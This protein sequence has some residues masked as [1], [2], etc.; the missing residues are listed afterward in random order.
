MA[1]IDDQ[2]SMNEIQRVVKDEVAIVARVNGE[3]VATFGLIM[4]RWWFNSKFSFFTDRWLFCYPALWNKGVGARLLAE[5]GAVTK[6]AEAPMIINGHVKR[7]PNGV[8][9]T[10]PLTIRPHE[11]DDMN[12]SDA[13]KRVSIH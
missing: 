12:W 8:H 10:K 13:A 9:F 4:V 11:V 6:A 7:R 5:A 3:M 1:P 2:E